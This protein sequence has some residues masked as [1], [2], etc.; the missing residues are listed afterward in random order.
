MKYYYNLPGLKITIINSILKIIYFDPQWDLIKDGG[1]IEE[2]LLYSYT[3]KQ[4]IW[5][6]SKIVMFSQE[7]NIQYFV[8]LIS[9]LK[10]ETKVN[11]L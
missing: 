5:M 2:P 4:I 7:Y 10:I 6:N 8:F 11:H 1:L 9:L 3:H